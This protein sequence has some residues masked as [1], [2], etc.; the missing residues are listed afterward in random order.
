MTL[1]IEALVLLAAA[2]VALGLCAVGRAWLAWVAVLAAGLGFW[3]SA[4]G[5]PGWAFFPLLSLFFLAALVTGIEPLRR[6]VLTPPL[7]RI[8]G[9]ILPRMS[10]TERAAL[11][12]GTVWWDGELFSGA[13]NWE[14]LLAFQPREL[15]AREQEFLSGPVEEL[16]RRLDDFQVTRDGDLPGPIWDFIKDRGFM[17]MIIP[18]EH[19]G[20]GFSALMNS[21]VVTRLSSRCVTAAVTVMVPNSLGPAELLVHYGTEEQKRYFLPRLARGEE[22]PCFA[23]TEPW[24]GS[25]AASMRSSGVVCRGN[26]AGREVLGIRLNWNKRYITLAPGGTLL[27]LAFKLSDPEH[28]LGATVELGITLALIPIDTPGVECGRRHD[29]MG[30]PFLNGPTTGA[31]V[32]VPVDAI[33]GGP[34]MAGKGWR[35]L[36]QCLSAGRGI[37]LPALSVGAAQLATR[38]VGAYATL[39]EQFNLSIGRFEG[40]EE[41]LA[42]I[43]GL[44]YI[45]DAGR[46]MTVGAID[47]GEKPGVVTAIMKAYSTEAMRTVINDAMDI[48]GGA[49]VCRGPRNV[50]AHAYQAVPIGITVEGAN[51]LTRTM[52]IFGQGAIRCHPWVQAEMKGAAEKNLAEFDR[53]FFGHVNFV[54]QNLG[55]AW[56]LGVSN[57][58]FASAPVSGP[59]G[60][61]MRQLTRLSSAFALVCDFAMGTLGGSLKRKETITGRLADALAWQ[62]LAS[63]AVKRFVADGSPERDRHVFRWS[64]EHA[65]FQIQTALAGVLDNL[66]NRAAAGVLR[67]IVFPLGQRLKPPS[68]RLGSQVASE[69]LED[70]PLRLA[71]T[72]DIYLPAEEE[73][74]LGQ[75]EAA[76]DKVM[77]ALPAREK[78]REAQRARKLER[79]LDEKVLAQAVQSGVITPQERELI[80][81]GEAARSEAVQVDAFEPAA[82]HAG[83]V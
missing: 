37:S 1:L 79:G 19:G 46:R 4:G 29:P 54:F 58:A 77:A 32:F 67:P 31:D 11:E 27:G 34:A 69:L 63:A 16:C 56:F 33:I 70:R 76:L 41:R 21:A 18:R 9:G 72:G 80:R 65:L 40:I 14:K 3:Y 61:F 60:S 13:P 20:L 10:E 5:S 25:D 82:M 52:I 83:V 48:V 44:T 73:P 71:L 49:G 26:H 59:A 12:A 66:P 24:A 6:L 62:Y 38:T 64:M 75:L 68:D 7:L 35:M 47:A 74:G 81:S 28:L 43:A 15:S 42:R 78:I 57:G 36:M 53:A 45:V 50:L 55:R 30:I 8:V 22:V 51:I 2:L 17:G 23:L 39:R